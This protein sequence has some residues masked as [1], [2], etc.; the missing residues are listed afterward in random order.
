MDKTEAA[1]NHDTLLLSH[2]RQGSEAALDRLYEKYW[3]KAFSQAYKRLKDEDQAKDVVQEVFVRIWFNRETVIDNFPAYL[4]VCVKNQVLKLIA[5]SDRTSP[6]LDRLDELPSAFSADA[7]FKTKEFDK[8]YESVVATLP[9]KRQRIFRLHFH[10]DL[11][12]KAIAEQM[13]ITRKTVQ[14]QLGKAIQQ[15]RMILLPCLIVAMTL[16]AMLKK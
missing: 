9:P 16:I 7:K 12:T 8:I 10:E 13:G 4:S 2:L 14:N 6:L 3:E 11:T 15:L 1:L 5:E